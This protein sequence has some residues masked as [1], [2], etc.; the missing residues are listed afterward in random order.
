MQALPHSMHLPG[1]PPHMPVQPGLESY[2]PLMP[3]LSLDSFFAS[4][5]ERDAAARHAQQPP[6]LMENVLPAWGEDL[7]NVPEGSLQAG[8]DWQVLADIS[9]PPTLTDSGVR[10][11]F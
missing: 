1:Q 7:N 5:D 2:I 4:C 11:R 6:A 10:L 3:S 9:I 8:A